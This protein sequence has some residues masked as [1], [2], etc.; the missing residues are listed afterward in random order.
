MSDAKRL[1]SIEGSIGC[2]GP[3]VILIALMLFFFLGQICSDVQKISGKLDELIQQK[4]S[5]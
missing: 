1:A 2:L 3:V 4:D 5:K